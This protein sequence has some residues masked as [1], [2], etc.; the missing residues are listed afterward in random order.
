MS[1]KIFFHNDDLESFYRFVPITPLSIHLLMK[2][3]VLLLILLPAIYWACAMCWTLFL[4][5]GI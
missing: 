3:L 5:Q 4:A 1:K 2:V